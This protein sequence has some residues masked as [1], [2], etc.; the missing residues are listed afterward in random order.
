MYNGI[1]PSPSEAAFMR[2]FYT[3][4][5]V[6][7]TYRYITIFTPYINICNLYNNT[8]NLYN[9]I[10]YNIAICITMH[11]MFNFS[12]RYFNIFLK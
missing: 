6:H 11:T 9:K 10:T 7:T 12:H 2:V 3:S 1:I 5:P 8:Y 4:I